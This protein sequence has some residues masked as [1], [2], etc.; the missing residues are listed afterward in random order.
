MAAAVAAALSF[1]R[2]S[3]TDQRSEG[4]PR[5][6]S[7]DTKATKNTKEEKKER[8]TTEKD[9]AD[10]KRMEFFILVKRRQYPI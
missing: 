1:F 8:L 10:E 4:I 6:S 2:I 9:E 5:G 3:R 7:F